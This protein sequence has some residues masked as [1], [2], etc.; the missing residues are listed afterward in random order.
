MRTLV[1]A[2]R[3]DTRMVETQHSS[4]AANP[5]SLRSKSPRCPVAEQQVATQ[6]LVRS[7]QDHGGDV[8]REEEELELELRMCGGRKKA[9]KR[10]RAR[11]VGEGT[12]GTGLL[13]APPP[14]M[15][16][17][18]AFVSSVEERGEGAQHV[19]R[20]SM[21]MDALGEQQGMRVQCALPPELEDECSSR[22]AALHD[23]SSPTGISA[24]RA[25]NRSKSHSIAV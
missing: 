17:H 14:S 1:A 7:L 21:M 10:G 15:A 20:R 22:L 16:R 18:C 19:E 24:T 9:C 25:R 5:L 12:E 13:L 23:R 11:K 3:S 4:M 6:V 8:E 2:A